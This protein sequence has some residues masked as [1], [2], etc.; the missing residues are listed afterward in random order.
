MSQKQ[1][2]LALVLYIVL[3]FAISLAVTGTV[4]PTSAGQRLWVLSAIGMWFFSLISAPWF[5][6]PRDSL[7]NCVAAALLMSL[8][9]FQ[10]VI[11]LRAPLDIFR[12]IAVAIAVIT[13]TLAVVAMVFRDSDPYEHPKLYAVARLAYRL[14]DRIGQGELVF[15]PP[16]L[17]SIVGYYQD[18]P[19]QQLWLLFGWVILVATRPIEL[20]I[21]I[22]GEITVA[23]K[24]QGIADSIGTITRVDNPNIVRVALSSE[25]EWQPD[26]VVTACLPNGSQVNVLCLFSHIQETQ[27]VGTGLA[28]GSATEALPDGVPGQVYRRN[29]VA[30]A[31]DILKDLSGTREG[32]TLIG[33]VVEDSSISA[34]K[35][36]VSPTAS[37]EEGVLTFC[38]QGKQIVYYQIIDART[39]E[40]TFERNPRGKHIVTAAQLGYLDPQKGFVKYGWLPS[41][42]TPVFIPR[43]PVTFDIASPKPDEFSIGMLPDSKVSVRAGLFDLLEFHS[44]I[45]G[46]TGTG[47]TELAFDLIRKALELE[48]KVFCVDF[49]N[50]Y[51]QRLSDQSPES[52]GLDD[53]LANELDQKLFAVETGTYGAPKEKETLKKFVDEIRE[54]VR[55][56]VDNFLSK[57]GP[58]LGIFELRNL[59]MK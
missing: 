48:V 49:T 59:S 4:F 25:A 43:S 39:A 9:D 5:R 1:R 7:A 42:N 28:C 35:F 37:L 57:P 51:R 47:K 17:V 22:I 10:G 33:F 3:L 36:E 41:M 12:W 46:V 55:K 44:A 13:A 24:A 30:N 15:T 11:L 20:A 27:L 34:I 45:L 31:E 54:P 21:R 18:A 8:L 52:L 26:S 16:A 56:A 23:A 58:G 14:S 2:L 38:R 29:D 40:E 32:A 53:K 6:P 50:E 19:T